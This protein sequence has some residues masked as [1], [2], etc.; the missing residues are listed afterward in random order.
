MFRKRIGWTLTLSGVLSI[1]L[2]WWGVSRVL[3]DDPPAFAFWTLI[4]VGFAV[5]L[6]GLGVL[7]FGKL[8]VTS[9]IK[10]D[11]RSE[12]PQFVLGFP[13]CRV[14]ISD[15]WKKKVYVLSSKHRVYLRVSPLARFMGL[16][17]VSY[18]VFDFVG[19]KLGFWMQSLSAVGAFV[20]LWVGS[21]LMQSKPPE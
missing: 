1:V 3:P 18:A 5:L 7:I 13:F 19:L 4:T 14:V 11:L 12:R 2:G 21:G 16:V 6:L 20:I 15:E 9:L 8:S 17:M 10:I